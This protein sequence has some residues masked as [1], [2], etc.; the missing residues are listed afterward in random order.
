MDI[1]VRCLD[2]EWVLGMSAL[3]LEA[4]LEMMLNFKVCQLYV[5]DDWYE[6]SVEIYA[7]GGG[8]WLFRFTRFSSCWGY[9]INVKL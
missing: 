5:E 4:L 8:E 7:L 3:T 2:V 9:M 6:V 1:S